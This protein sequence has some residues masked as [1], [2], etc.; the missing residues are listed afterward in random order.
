MDTLRYCIYQS[1]RE[2]DE[3]EAN[4]LEAE[5]IIGD[6]VKAYEELCPNPKVRPPI[7]HTNTITLLNLLLSA[8]R[9]VSQCR[10]LKQ[11][12]EEF[13]AAASV[14]Y[15]PCKIVCNFALCGLVSYIYV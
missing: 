4:L 8:D 5:R 7:S 14:S 13:N 12:V 10:E 1:E 9:S 6:Y 15:A 3:N 11:E 2:L